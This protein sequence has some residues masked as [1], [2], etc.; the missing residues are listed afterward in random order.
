MV[1]RIIIDNT[2]KLD[3]SFIQYLLQ[4]SALISLRNNEEIDEVLYRNAKVQIEK[5]AP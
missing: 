4:L 3:N 5:F 1:E 2:N